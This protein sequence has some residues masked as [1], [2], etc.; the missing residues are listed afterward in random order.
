MYETIDA[1]SNPDLA[2][3]MVAQALSAGPAPQ[4]MTPP[5]AVQPPPDTHVDLLGGLY[6]PVKD[7]TYLT[8][9]V[10]ELT[11]HDEE[12]LARVTGNLSKTLDT[13]LKRG[14][15]RLGDDEATESMLSS[16]LA[17]DRDW[18]I[19]A[20][21]RAT[22]GNEVSLRAKCP[23]CATE[24]D[25]IIDLSADVPVQRLDSPSDS[26]FEKHLKSGK[27]VLLRLPN[28]H[29]QRAVA[30]AEDRNTAVLTTLLL[31][32]CVEE[33][34]GFPIT[35]A[36]QVK[37]LSMRD[38]DEI[39]SLLTASSPGPD[40]EAITKPCTDCGETMSLPLTLGAIFRF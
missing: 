26:R 18:L 20:I 38:R 5:P 22:F 2:N 30:S 36:E 27:K 17:G 39:V 37:N 34:N 13:L 3:Q 1:T 21:R 12:A 7:T 16:L 6:D 11:G 40:L 24:Q 14:V 31:S 8:A 32:K 35:G 19:L 10:R 23:A 9:E 29:A 4:E 28:G 15:V 25:A 33:I